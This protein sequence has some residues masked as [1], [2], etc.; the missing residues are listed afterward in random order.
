M[1]FFFRLFGGFFFCF[2]FLT[3]ILDFDIPSGIALSATKRISSYFS[4]HLAL[5]LID[6]PKFLGFNYQSWSSLPKQPQDKLSKGAAYEIITPTETVR[7]ED[8]P[9]KGG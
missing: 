1:F 4:R 8:V 3:D 9:V 5:G 2:V 7:N 6:N